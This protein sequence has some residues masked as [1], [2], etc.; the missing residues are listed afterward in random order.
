MRFSVFVSERIGYGTRFMIVE[1]GPE[2]SSGTGSRGDI[3][4]KEEI[5]ELNRRVK[6]GRGECL[7]A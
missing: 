5:D 2:E 3:D 6:V 1:D 4:G 7:W